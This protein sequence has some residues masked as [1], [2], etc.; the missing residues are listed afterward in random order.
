MFDRGLTKLIKTSTQRTAN[1]EGWPWAAIGIVAY[2]LRRSL[3]YEEPV[4]SFKVTSG[5]EVTVSV[6]DPER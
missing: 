3:R 5:H 2:L 1:G 4:Q 6:R